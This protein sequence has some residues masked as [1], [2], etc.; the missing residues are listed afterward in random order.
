MG[1]T[2]GN[3]LPLGLTY[4]GPIF[5]MGAPMSGSLAD[6]DGD[7][8]LDLLG[9]T[10]ADFVLL[11]RGLGNGAFGKLEKI[12]IGG[13][14]LPYT[15]TVDD[16]NGDG[17]F[18]VVTPNRSTGDV[19]VMLGLGGGEFAE[20]RRFR[21]G[22]RPESLAVGDLNNDGTP[23]IAVA[24]TTTSDVTILLNR[25][26][27][28]FESIGSHRTGASSPNSI[29]LADFD[30]DGNL[31]VAVGNQVVGVSV[32][33]G[34]GDGDLMEPIFTRTSGPSINEGVIFTGDFNEDGITDLVGGDALLLGDGTGLFALKVA[35]DSTGLPSDVH[36]VGDL[37]GDGHLDLLVVQDSGP[38][39]LIDLDRVIIPM[40]GNGA[41][42]FSR[43][44][45]LRVAHPARRL[46]VGD[47][48]GD[49]NLDIASQIGYVAFGL[50]DGSFS[51]ALTYETSSFGEVA[52]A[53]L[54]RDG[55]TDI[56][57]TD[58]EAV[59]KVGVSWCHQRNSSA[60]T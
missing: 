60:T 4:A 46:T 38:R 5:S 40:L 17:V 22:L 13:G 2:P 43:R 44:G 33:L 52:L 50:G 28:E 8:V 19:S 9:A 14:E 30:R 35:V 16:L 55:Q 1:V 59:R 10:E 25:G 47:V 24:N 23:D 12:F 56:L 11:R 31:D 15:V 29:V 21:V 7:G 45:R 18:D 26:A 51:S 37:N 32:F 54:N 58:G 41:G 27:G 34:R 20:A 3:V 39:S 49:G 6:C 48:N 53:D 42:R 36:G 57:T